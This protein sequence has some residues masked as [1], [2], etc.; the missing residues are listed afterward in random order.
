MFFQS[1]GNYIQVVYLDEEDKPKKEMVRAT[2]ISIEYDLAGFSKFIRVHRS[3]FV[4]MNQV[5]RSEGNAQG[6][7]L[8]LK[9]TDEIVPVSRK[10][11]N[12]IRNQY[13]G[14]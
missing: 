6:I 8:F 10:F 13:V 3:Y 12:T 2:M 7:K 14:D 5:V 9:N 1:Q 4:N 11:V